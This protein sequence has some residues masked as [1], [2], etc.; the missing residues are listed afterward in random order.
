MED[1]KIPDGVETGAV[2]DAKQEGRFFEILKVGVLVGPG[3]VENQQSIIE[4]EFSTPPDEIPEDEDAEIEP[5][6]TTTEVPKFVTKW[7]ASRRR[8]KLRKSDQDSK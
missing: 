6:I 4:V 2:P 8:K 3:G 7:G 5:S 1:Q